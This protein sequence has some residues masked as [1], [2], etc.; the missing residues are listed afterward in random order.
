MYEII[1]ANEQLESDSLWPKIIPNILKQ[2]DNL[3]AIFIVE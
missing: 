1:E 2:T 3:I